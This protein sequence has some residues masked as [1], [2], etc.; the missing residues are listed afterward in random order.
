MIKYVF[1]FVGVACA[2]VALSLPADAH[3]YWLQPERFDTAAG[4]ELDV[5][6]F[7]GDHFV[8]GAERPY[9]ARMTVDFRLIGLKHIVDLKP[10]AKDGGRPFATI[11]PQRNG[12]HLVVLERD[13]SHIE[14]EPE[15]FNSYLEHEGLSRIVELRKKAS[16]DH[17]VGKERY[18]RYLKTLI[19]VGGKDDMTYKKK[20]GHRL[21]ILPQANPSLVK[22]GQR[23]EFL[24][25]FD[26]IPLRNAQVSAYNRV[27]EDVKT[28]E[29]RTNERGRIQFE[30]D[31]PGVWL[32]RLVH[33]RRC[34]EKT[35]DADWE[36][37]WAAYTFGRNE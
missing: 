21:E 12:S 2:A 29:S 20:V 11:Q 31:R 19:H 34:S 30:L 26:D 16:E 35:D 22:S 32:V 9:Q 15:K 10:E 5:Q 7:V 8:S 3:D 28:Q 14:L 23:L 36:S 37:F 27:G 17:A 24:V 18:R 13:W 4:K 33:M 1:G 25:L 6:L